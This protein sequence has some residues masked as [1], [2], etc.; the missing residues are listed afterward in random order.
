MKI[1][2]FRSFARCG[3]LLA[4]A[5]LTSLDVNAA[6][7]WRT[8]QVSARALHLSFVGEPTVGEPLRPA[9]RAFLVKATE[10]IR[11]QVKLAEVG[12]SHGG[13]ADVRSHAQKLA[14]D[15]RQLSDALEA[16][17]RRKGGI[18][19]MPVGGTSENYDKLVAASAADFDREFI[20]TA[21]KMT[22]SV[23]NLFEQATAEAKDADVRA[24]AAA[25]LPVLRAH[26]TTTTELQ[27]ASE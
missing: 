12:L 3:A 20:R 21:A 17:I 6:A 10:S 23:L 2:S 19:D 26:R 11:Q 13:S 24:F 5:G 9:E 15:C 25:Q 27:K 18:A 16:L 1:S 8:G 22:D 4:F 14:G 7:P